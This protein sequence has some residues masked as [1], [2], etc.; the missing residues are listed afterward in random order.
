MRLQ[1]MSKVTGSGYLVMNSLWEHMT[2][3]IRDYNMIRLEYN[4]RQESYDPSY[5]E[6][7]GGED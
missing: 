2:M 6:L 5:H 1:V 4:L 7:I 3:M